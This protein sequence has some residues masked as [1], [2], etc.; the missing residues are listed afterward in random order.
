MKILLNTLL[1]ILWVPAIPFVWAI[2]NHKPKWVCWVTIPWAMPF[3]TIG[4]L[5][6]N[7]LD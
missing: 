7:K 3:L 2:N 5:L 1:F 4:Q 6:L